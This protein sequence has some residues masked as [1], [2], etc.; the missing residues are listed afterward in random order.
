MTSPLLLWLSAF[1]LIHLLRGITGI[2][3]LNN[4]PTLQEVIDTAPVEDKIMHMADI[5]AVFISHIQS[6]GLSYIEGNKTKLAGY[7]ILTMLCLVVDLVLLAFA[8]WVLIGSD[9]VLI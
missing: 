2:R 5:S 8:I 3:I 7:G 6:K 4:T 9:M 1:H